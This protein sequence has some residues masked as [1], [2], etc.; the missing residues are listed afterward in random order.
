V[1]IAT[2]TWQTI[3]YVLVECLQS[4]ELWH[5]CSV[6]YKKERSQLAMSCVAGHALHVAY[7]LQLAHPLQSSCYRCA[8]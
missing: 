8:A 6:A 5:Y 2:L 1:S 3:E 7:A 4:D